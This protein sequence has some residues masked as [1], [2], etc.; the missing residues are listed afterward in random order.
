MDTLKLGAS[1]NAI[2][3]TKKEQVERKTPNTPESWLFGLIIRV[4]DSIVPRLAGEIEETL[5]DP[6]TINVFEC[7]RL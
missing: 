2:K 1:T 5:T 3:P 6:P 7:F 4:T